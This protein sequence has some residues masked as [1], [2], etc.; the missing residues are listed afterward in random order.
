M[1]YDE[2][3][4]AGVSV[5]RIVGEGEFVAR[6]ERAARHV[7]REAVEEGWLTASADRLV[8]SPLQRAVAE[9]ADLVGEPAADDGAPVTAEMLFTALLELSGSRRGSFMRHLAP[10]LTPEQIARAWALVRNTTDENCR[11]N[12]LFSLAPHLPPELLAQAPAVVPGSVAARRGSELAA[13]VP[14]LPAEQR[15]E[16]AAA[17]LTALTGSATL[18]G[19]EMLTL[20][21]WLDPEQID[22]GV[23][24]LSSDPDD[25]RAV[26]LA[27]LAEYLTPAQR[28][29]A[30]RVC[31]R[32]RDE[33]YRFVALVALAPYLDGTQRDDLVAAALTITAPEF[34]ARTLAGIAAHLPPRL[35]VEVV[36]AAVTA[37]I[38]ADDDRD[39]LH[40][41]TDLAGL[42]DEA[43]L[44][45]VLAA[46]ARTAG[47]EPPWTLTEI[48][49]YL[50]HEQLG[51]ALMILRPY[52]D[53][54]E[55]SPWVAVSVLA[56]L[57][58]FLREDQRR[59]LVDDVFRLAVAYGSGPGVWA[60]YLTREQ[61]AQALPIVL[62]QNDHNIE[63]L[64]PYLD[65]GQLDQVCADM[66]SRADE[67]ERGHDLAGLA[68]YLGPERLEQAL[69]HVTEPANRAGLL[70]AIAT[71]S[72]AET[73]PATL[74]RALHAASAILDPTVRARTLAEVAEHLP[75]VQRDVAL[76][77]AFAATSHISD[78]GDRIL[79]LGAIADL[80]GDAKADEDAPA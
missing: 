49:P 45:A 42:L 39:R 16:V 70:L 41:M 47:A 75:P 64:M 74:A 32:I 38:E 78:E 34:R 3:I 72:G 63:G 80:L 20:A 60:P 37:V 55:S 51:R 69:E 77:R 56:A 61:I 57:L 22:L 58:P 6:L 66:L 5:N 59:P 48:A 76:S 19:Y 71:T 53:S 44:D 35:R 62:A 18:L 11:S 50:T 73:R 36:A 67:A 54:A 31:T 8:M 40:A 9:L 7:A 26:T 43:Q 25:D 79:A 24:I 27:K 28:D 33:S 52:L 21:R 12:M 23:R 65:A 2:G 30:I 29:G 13:L 68:R 1:S 10:C 14:L 46:I 4:I 17:A 15:A